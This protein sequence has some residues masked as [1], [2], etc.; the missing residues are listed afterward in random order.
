MS[1]IEEKWFLEWFNYHRNIGVTYFYIYTTVP[2]LPN[3][4]QFPSIFWQTKWPNC[5]NG[6]MQVDA[7]LHAKQHSAHIFDWLIFLDLDEYIVPYPLD[8]TNN[9]QKVL[10]TQTTSLDVTVCTFAPSH[11]FSPETQLLT[12]LERLPKR[13]SCNWTSKHF[14]KCSTGKEAVSSLKKC[15]RPFFPLRVNHYPIRSLEDF[16][17]KAKIG[18]PKNGPCPDLDEKLWWHKYNMIMSVPKKDLVYD[19]DILTYVS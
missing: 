5:D 4:F 2:N 3:R 1:E 18:W 7:Y 11:I 13:H 9:L 17:A 15:P 8:P 19:R 12:T 16:V 14:Y 10:S 6:Y